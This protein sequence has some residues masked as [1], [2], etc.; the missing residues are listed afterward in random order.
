MMLTV[1]YDGTILTNVYRKNS[2]RSGVFFAAMNIFKE[3][4]KRSDVRVIL[5]FS[6]ARFVDGIHLRNEF[7]PGVDILFESKKA[8]KIFLFLVALSRKINSSLPFWTSSLIQ[9]CC[10]FVKK[11]EVK[12]QGTYFSPVFEF[13]AW[14]AK[15]DLLKRYLL[16]HDAIPYKFPEYY[17][18]KSFLF[19][20]KVRRSCSDKDFF[21]F[22]S[23]NSFRD[24]KNVY[25]FVNDGN[26]LVNHLAANLNFKHVCDAFLIKTVRKKYGI[27]ANKRYVFSLCTL[28]PRKNLIRTLRTFLQFVKKNDVLDLVWVLGGGHWESFIEQFNKEIEDLSICKDL[29]IRAGYV[30]DA[31]LPILYSGAEW[32]VYT[33]QYEGFGLPPL[34]A[35]QCGCPVITS[36]N[37]SLPEVVGDAGVMID[38]N[39]DEQ[40]IAAYE[41][42]YFNE[43]FR[44]LKSLEGL[45]RSKRFSWKKTTDL[46]L[47]VMKREAFEC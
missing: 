39:S 9:K 29:F 14:T 11:N 15:Q 20:E 41:K 36:N 3:I 33:S 26:S 17:R 46:I 22:V 30:D 28:E 43:S 21:F 27:P 38:W 45:E 1:V 5:Y 19:L 23:Q 42:Y 47:E 13:P 2:E 25:P 6:P 44:K 24:Y 16:L 10:L 35:M 18:D 8:N 7:F 12:L 34:E 40:H 4:L 37:S 31:D 32:F